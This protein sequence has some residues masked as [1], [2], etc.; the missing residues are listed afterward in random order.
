MNIHIICTSL[1]HS[2]WEELQGSDRIA[3]R[4]LLE[5]TMM[6]YIPPIAPTTVMTMPN[7]TCTVQALTMA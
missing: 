3:E 1:H 6:P 5:S 4:L 7:K 2:E